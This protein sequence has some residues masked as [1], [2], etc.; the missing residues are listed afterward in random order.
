MQ[1]S[2]NIKCI[3]E[4]TGSTE[5]LAVLSVIIHGV[6]FLKMVILRPQ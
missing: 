4:L 5:E 2:L 3:L 1:L 6:A